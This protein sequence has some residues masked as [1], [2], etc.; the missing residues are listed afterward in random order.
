MLGI[1]QLPERSMAETAMLV[2][3]SRSLDALGAAYSRA[4]AVLTGSSCG[5]LYRL[6]TDL[7]RLFFATG[8]DHGFLDDY[9]RGLAKCDPFI[10]SVLCDGRVVDG[11]SLIGADHWSRSTSYDLLNTWGF[12]HN[13]CGPLRIDGQIVGVAYTAV[14]GRRAPY[15]AEY[16]QC[17]DL[18]CRAASLALT[19]LA[20]AGC[21]DGEDAS[22]GPAS[23]LDQLPPRAAEV[24]RLLLRGRSNKEIAREMGISDQTVKD[25]VANLCRR[26]GASNRTELAVRLQAGAPPV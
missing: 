18:I 20:E 3:E 16:R 21:L 1:R 5:G 17:M 13:M 2:A 12:C 25:H 8:A 4:T 22:S 14:R 7:P 23:P 15:T 9:N 10:D 6:T 26:F 11:V 19:N 24:A